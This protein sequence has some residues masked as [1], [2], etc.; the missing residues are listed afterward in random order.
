MHH[1]SF[2]FSNSKCDPIP[3][4][5][6]LSFLLKEISLIKWTLKR[7]AENLLSMQYINIWRASNYEAAEPLQALI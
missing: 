4:T 7:L 3:L 2:Q 1:P 5:H 6:T